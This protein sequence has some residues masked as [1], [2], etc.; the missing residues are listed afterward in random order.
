MIDHNS[1]EIRLAKAG[2]AQQLHKAHMRS[3]REICIHEH[4]PDEVSGWGYR[5][6][7]A[8]W[9]ES[10]ERIGLDCWVWVVEKKGVIEGHAFISKMTEDKAHIGGLYLTPTVVGAGFGGQLMSLMF[11]AARDF[12]VE[13]IVLESTLTAHAFYRHHGFEDVGACQTAEIGGYPVRYIPMQFI[14]SP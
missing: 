11:Q 13:K 10:I 2:D 14:V 4:G 9:N 1:G 8:H 3:I 5:E 12:G 7:W 6:K